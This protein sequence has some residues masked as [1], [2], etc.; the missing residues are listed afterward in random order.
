MIQGSDEWFQA[1]CG[2]VTASRIADVMARTRNGYGASRANYMAQLISERLTGIPADT[3]Q[4]QAMLWGIETEPHARAAYEFITD[5]EVI[6]AGF[7][8][9][10]EISDSGASPDGLVGIN[11]LVE[12][13]CPNTA[14]HIDTLLTGTIPD[15]YIKQMQWQMDTIGR[16]YCDFVSFD[17]RMPENL[18]FWRK[19]VDRDDDLIATMREEVAKFLNELEAKIEALNKLREAA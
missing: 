12:F 9:H 10:P 1:R 14:T 5:I 6:E 7:I 13:K 8:E 17:P 3:Y 4:N 2:K 15:K 18:R 19:R 16:A 11:G